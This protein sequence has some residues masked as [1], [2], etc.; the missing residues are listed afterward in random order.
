M[1]GKALLFDPEIAQRILAA[2]T[3]AESKELGRKV[4]QH[5]RLAWLPD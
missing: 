3:P 4:S 1:F 2:Q 5:R